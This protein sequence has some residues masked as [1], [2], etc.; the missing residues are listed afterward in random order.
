[1]MRRQK[2]R[3]SDMPALLLLLLLL[4]VLIAPHS[5]GIRCRRKAPGKLDMCSGCGRQAGTHAAWWRWG[6]SGA[7]GQAGQQR[8][9]LYVASAHPTGTH[10]QGSLMHAAAH[11]ERCA[12]AVQSLHVHDAPLPSHLADCLQHLHK[13]RPEVGQMRFMGCTLCLASAGA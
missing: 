11:M 7:S 6:A 8:V 5:A 9:L 4:L 10:C 12:G 3:V 13:C 1:M 2:K